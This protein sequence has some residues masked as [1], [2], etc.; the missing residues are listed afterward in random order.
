MFT[1]YY[2][3]SLYQQEIFDKE[4]IQF[5]NSNKWVWDLAFPAVFCREVVLLWDVFVWK[6]L[7]L[8]R[9]FS[10]VFI[11]SKN[12]TRSSEAREGLAGTLRF[13]QHIL[14]TSASPWMDGWNS[15]PDLLLKSWML[16]NKQIWRKGG[17]FLSLFS[18][19]ARELQVSNDRQP[20]P[21]RDVEGW[22]SLVT[23]GIPPKSQ[24]AIR[25]KYLIHNYSS[26]ILSIYIY[27]IIYI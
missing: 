10:Q 18:Q 19:E 26:I 2:S 17:Q 1:V 9:V 15:A 3:L 20:S 7:G 13:N 11:F 8:I 14:A 21:V 5:H 16:E 6:H 25:F 22:C 24:K 4:N 27:I 12:T 23:Y